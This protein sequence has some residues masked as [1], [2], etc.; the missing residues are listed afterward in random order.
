MRC[1]GVRS[2]H[3]NPIFEGF[4]PVFLYNTKIGEPIMKFTLLSSKSM[5]LFQKSIILLLLFCL[6]TSSIN[7]QKI[8]AFSEDKATF[9]KEFDTFFNSGKQDIMKDL[10]KKF[11]K[12]VNSGLF[13]EVEEIPIIIATCNHMLKQKLTA[14]PYFSN[15]VES[16]L[17]VKNVAEG[18]A[19]FKNWHN[20]LNDILSNIEKRKLKPFKDYLTFSQAFFSEKKLKNSKS[21]INWIASND[22]HELVYENKEPLIKF[23][24]VDLIGARKKDSIVIVETQGIFRPVSGT[25]KGHGGKVT[26]ERHGMDDTYYALLDTFSINVL[27][28]IYDA[29]NVKLYYPSYFP[30]MSIEGDLQDKVVTQNKATEGSYPRFISRDSVLTIDAIG[31]GIQYRGGFRLQGTT[32]YG[33]GS[34]DAKASIKVADQGKTILKALSELFV[35]KKG[36]RIVSESVTTTMYFNQDSIYH[37]SVNFKYLIPARELSL[38]RGKRGSDRNPF[39]S[40]IHQVNMN[41]EKIDWYMNNDSIIIGQKKLGIAG[42]TK[43]VE[44]ESLEYFEIGDYRRLQNISSTNPLSALKV[45]ADK[46]GDVI[47]AHDVAKY[48]NPKFEVSSIQSLLYDLVARG[49]INYDNDKELVYIKDKLMHYAR[50]SQQKVDYDGI[51]I[52]SSTEKES[53]AV[54]R[55]QDNTITTNGV[56]NIEFSVAQ[57]V[58][59]KPYGEQIILKENRDIDL[60]GKVFSGFSSLVGKDFHFN[61]DEFNIEMDSIR[62]FDLFVP[63]GTEDEKGNPNAV[64][65]GSRIENLKGVLLIDAPSNKSGQE[66]IAMFPSLNSKSNAFVYYDS[67]DTQHGCYGR[68]SF[69][70]LLDEFSFNSLDKYTMEDVKFDGTMHSADIFP[71]F[72]ESLVVMAEDLSLGFNTETTGSG[73]PAY[74][75]KG[76]FD[77]SIELSNKGFLAKGEIKYLKATVNSEDIIFRPKQM[78]A[79]A[80][81]F[82]LEEDRN[83]AVK[84]PKAEG[85]DVKINW[86]PYTDSMYIRSDEVPFNIFNDGLHTLEK[87]LI[88]TPD[89]LKGRSKFDWDKGAMDSQ[90]FSFGPHS[91][92]ADTASLKI[93][94]LGA[95]DIALSTENVNAVMDFD[96]QEGLVKSNSFD[97]KTTLPYNQYETTMNEFLWDMKNESITFK[98]EVG[99][100]KGFLS[101]HPD[102]DSLRFEGETAFYSLKTNELKIGGVDYIVSADAF[103][104][105]ETQEI[106]V[107]PGGVITRLKN[108][109]IVCDT[110]SKYH[111]IN[112]AEVDIK[113]RKDYFANGYY[114]YNLP[115]KEQE[116]TFAKIVGSRI[117]KGA[118]HEKRTATRATGE[119]KEGDKFYID[120]KT[121]FRGTITMDSDKQNLLFE[122]FA[123]MDAPLLPGGQWFS[124][125]SEGDKKDLKIGYDVPKNYKGDPLRTG[126]YLSK[127]TGVCYPRVMMPLYI[128]K[129]RPIIEAKGIFDF[130]NVEDRFLFADSTVLVDKTLMGSMVEFHNKDAKVIANGPMN[131]GSGLDYVSVKSAGRI[132]TVFEVPDP[133]ADPLVPQPAAKT[134]FHVT[135]GIDMIIP[136][137]LLRILVTD[138]ESS[139]FDASNINYNRDVVYYKKAL[140]QF[141]PDVTEHAKITSTLKGGALD[142]PKKYNVH[143]F[144]FGNVAMKWNPEYQSF[145]NREDKIGIIAINGKM[146]SKQIPCKIEFKM[147]SNGDDRVYIHIESPSG[148]YYFFGYKQGILNVGSNNTKF[149]DELAGMKKKEVEFKMDDGEIYQVLPVNEGTATMFK[150]RVLDARKGQE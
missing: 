43:E 116:I 36:E 3:K 7:A 92:D 71:P 148:Y 81:R 132:E 46:E 16:L 62:Y 146:I 118:R 113:G 51:K 117:G 50:A 144:M 111:V 69:Y 40:S 58:A 135:A 112:R 9:M 89:G 119:V 15:Y 18:S 149:N 133:K 125:N 104:Y 10:F 84:F 2:Y 101:I 59:V 114:E 121:E 129:D 14:R 83:G 48:L 41:S 102:Q 70:F 63:D 82:D 86:K 32:V 1:C 27:K 142:L 60:S 120:R 5:V 134:E 30:G 75:K 137:K 115:N 106:Q 99:K 31:E 12:Q 73:F 23:E 55:L 143:T 103:V 150:N 96:K 78:L 126:F 52:L 19:R 85:F 65:I 45:A 33:F 25:W 124:I 54:L 20:I 53:N 72:E 67:K 77:G 94:A 74:S 97:G 56:K 57:K 147:P 109:R 26:W 61:Y 127:E 123:K 139:S 4:I 79:S 6:T 108:A 145:V 68:D 11:S 35:I 28:S 91:V 130:D 107:M 93:K 95:D 47:S 34:S 64:S 110:M 8:T 98:A 49:F 37:P 136:E 21:G 29:K 87:E 76:N 100:K 88:L 44:F 39:F 22:K 140:A 42:S 138:L 24:K 122:G 90:L 128:R 105:P 141:I 13:E 38:S 131:I 17:L 66:D 80:E